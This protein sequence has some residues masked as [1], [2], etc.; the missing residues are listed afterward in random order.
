M[1]TL[2]S[3]NA[4]LVHTVASILALVFGSMVLVM[5]KGTK[6]HVMI[7]YAYVVS[8]AVLIV[9]AFMIYRLFNGFGVFHF[10]AILSL[11]TLSFGMIPI[12]T[13]KPA[14]TWKYLHFSFMYWSVVG[15]YAAFVAEVLTRIPDTPFFG[16]VVIATGIVML[17][18]GVVF[19]V[20]K[21]E[22]K[23]MFKTEH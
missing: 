23:R 2:Q 22:W 10:A 6:K 1:E 18:G 15:L 16:M 9:T 11:I 5:A 17:I 19:K 12:W 13:K 4:G 14:Q 20:K 8:M 7:G 3:F 21:S